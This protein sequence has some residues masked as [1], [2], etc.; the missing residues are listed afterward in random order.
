MQRSPCH[1][2]R[3]VTRMQFKLISDRLLFF[4]KL[5]VYDVHRAGLGEGGG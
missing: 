1:P 5:A 2:G 4:H 3:I